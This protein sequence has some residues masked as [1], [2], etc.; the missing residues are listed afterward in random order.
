MLRIIKHTIIW[1]SFGV[2]VTVSNLL[3]ARLALRFN[4]GPPVTDGCFIS[5]LTSLPL[6]FC[7]DRLV[8]HVRSVG[9]K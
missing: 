3:D 2:V 7:L 6:D 1:V 9:L 8:Y 5:H 4:P